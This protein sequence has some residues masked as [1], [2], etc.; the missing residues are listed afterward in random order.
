MN[1][2]FLSTKEVASI[3]GVDPKTVRRYL[4]DGIIKGRRIGR[5]YRVPLESISELISGDKKEHTERVPGLGI[6]SSIVNQKGGVGKTATAHNLADALRIIGRRVLLIDMD[7]Q[8]HLTASVGLASDDADANTY[9]ILLGSNNAIDLITSTAGGL[10]IITS[11]LDL[12]GAEIELVNS[13]MREF[14]LKDGIE[15][16]RSMYDHIIIDCP[17]SLGFLTL[18]ALVASSRVLIPVQCEYLSTR[19]LALIQRTIRHTQHPRL[20]PSLAIWKIIPTM[21]DVRKTHHRE[22]LEELRNQFGDLVFDP[23]IKTSVRITEAP[24]GGL[25]VIEYDPSGDATQAYVKLAREMDNHV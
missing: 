23:P 14:L 13:P 18:N 12:S 9:K 5:D 25:S 15:S 1:K 8:S 6:I 4:K 20:N 17:P 3:L 11:N 21:Y 2:P 22:V 10:D 19:G 7:P 16:I 24:A